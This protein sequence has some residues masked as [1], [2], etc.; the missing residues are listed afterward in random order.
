M[1]T[2]CFAYKE[3]GTCFALDKMYCQKEHCSFY[4]DKTKA[5]KEFYKN[6]DKCKEIIN[7]DIKKHFKS[8]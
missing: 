8:L 5:K 6:F 7:S 1:N 3:N 4:K 2:R